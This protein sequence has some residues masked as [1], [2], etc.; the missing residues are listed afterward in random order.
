MLPDTKDNPSAEEMVI[1]LIYEE[2]LFQYRINREYFTLPQLYSFIFRI[3][4][5]LQSWDFPTH[6]SR[7]NIAKYYQL[8]FSI[9]LSYLKNKQTFN[10][11]L[12]VK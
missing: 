6:Q 9:F 11:C 2:P 10:K 5:M 1:F 8:S 3:P 12:K 7:A 4:F